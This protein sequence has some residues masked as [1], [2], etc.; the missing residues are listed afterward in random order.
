MY[1]IYFNSGIIIIH[2]YNLH[3]KYR[4]FQNTR[5]L[6]GKNSGTCAIKNKAQ[7]P[8]SDK[9]FLS[10][11]YIPFTNAKRYTRAEEKKPFIDKIN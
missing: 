2:N 8:E 6:R 3:L 11:Q 9:L 4:C 1:I 10:H 5:L 7:N